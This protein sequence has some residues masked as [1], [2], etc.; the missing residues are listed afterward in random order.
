MT[1]EKKQL[2]YRPPETGVRQMVAARLY[3]ELLMTFQTRR[4]QAL[5]PVRLPPPYEPPLVSSPCHRNCPRPHP[6]DN[7]S[8]ARKCKTPRRLRETAESIRLSAE[9]LGLE[10]GVPGRPARHRG[11]SPFSTKHSALSRIT[12]S[13]LSS[14][15]FSPHSSLFC[16]AGRSPDP[17]TGSLA[18]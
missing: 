8:S 18:A 6:S 5:P 2:V 15:P 12:H 7:T 16:S 13:A 3:R 4:G 17:L 9:S 14:W 1:M 10:L 11:G